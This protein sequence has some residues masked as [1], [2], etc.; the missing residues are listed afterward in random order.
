MKKSTLKRV[1]GLLKPYKAYI[2]LSLALALVCVAA[3]LL[4]PIFCGRAI[5]AMIGVGKV[6]F[7]AVRQNALLVL[8]AALLYVPAQQ[9]MSMSNNRITFSVCRDLRTMLGIKQNKLPLSYT[10][11]HPTGDTV[12]R[13]VSDADSFSDGILMGFTQFFTGVITI[14]ATLGIM[15]YLN[16][17]IALCVILLTP[18]SIFTAR[19]IATKTHR[20]FKEQAVIRGE[21]TSLINEAIEGQRVIRAF[22]YEDKTLAAF[23]EINA[24]LEKASLSATFFSSLTNP[25]TR[26]VNNLVYAVVAAVSA[27]FAMGFGGITV[28]RLSV[29]LS[30]ASQYA[31]PFNEISGVI[32]EMQNALTCAARIFEILDEPEETPDPASPVSPAPEGHVRLKNV[33]FSYSKE[34]PLIQNLSLEAYRGQRVAIVGPTGCGKTT[35]I[36][37]LMR[38]Y[39]TDGGEIEVDGAN[40]RQMTRRDLRRRYAMVLQDTRLFAGTVR[41]NI[42]Y[43][44]E[45]ATSE[46]IEAAAKAAYAHS[47][48]RRLP[49]GYDT[50]IEEGGENLSVG[51]RQLLCIARAMLALP[52]MLIL[53]EATSSVD[54]RTEQKIQA[55]FAEMMKGRT[56]FVVAHRLSTVREADVIIVMNRGRI[57][58]QGTHRELMA[59]GGFYKKL[60]NS[61]FVQN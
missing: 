28:G 59:R 18:L 25:S 45:T 27:F 24:K 2:A 35:L 8:G 7:N 43:G 46:E 51:Q 40:I 42:A 53:D 32:T 19:F 33:C 57:E 31:K 23:D 60:Y 10:D 1:L 37:L 6:D 22:G 39:E 30:Y 36:N 26:L 52:H 41:E 15:L 56:S 20:F 34:R 55:A 21:E 5:D 61:Q 50:Y 54:T 16:A 38:F 44:K 11:T 9:L 47:F 12:S 14:A 58:E 3:Q 17:A 48:I 49:K 13:M 29:F 4:I